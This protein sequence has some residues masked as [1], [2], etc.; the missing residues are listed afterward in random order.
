MRL[1]LLSVLLCGS[2]ALGAADPS[3]FNVREFGAV[4]DGHALDT[5]AI[6]RAV[7][8]CASDGGGTVLLS[9]GKYLCG[10]IRLASHVTLEIGGGATLLAST[11][12]DDYPLLPDAWDAS[13]KIVAPLIYA[14]GAENISLTGRGTVDG[15]G[16]VWWRRQWL[17]TPKHGAH[18]ASNPAEQAEAAIAVRGRP[19]LVQLVRCRDVVISGL[20]FVDAPSWNLHPLLCENVRVDG[21]TIQADPISPNTD[22]INPE[23]CR[24]VQ[25][26]NCRIDNGDDCI[27]LKSGLDALGRKMGRPDEDITIANCVMGHGH[28]GVTIGSEMSGGVRNVT[29]INCVFHGTDNGIRIKSQRGRGGVVEGLTVSNIVMED[30]PHPFVIT[31]FYM[32]SDTATDLYPVDEGTPRFRGFLFSNI[33]ARGAQDAGSITGLRESPI[34]DISFSHVRIESATGFTCTNASE[35]AF[36]DTEIEPAKGPALVLKN[37][38]AVDTRGLRSRA[39]KG[40]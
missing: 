21:V 29:V 4:G 15:Q 13:L 2:A 40:N 12:P 8:A 38:D 16:P 22:G 3:V 30:V 26:V 9:P 27:T 37:A 14:D 36:F 18:A 39:A 17:L 24:N 5:A 35:I 33:S 34:S 20:N 1:K 31:T 10:T 32:G 11:N 25:I 7:A 23:S 6:N 19:Q 28:G